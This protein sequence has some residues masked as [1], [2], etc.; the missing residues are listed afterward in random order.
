MLNQGSPGHTAGSRVGHPPELC[1]GL[2]AGA[3]DPGAHAP[4]P[5]FLPPPCQDPQPWSIRTFRKK[6]RGPRPHGGAIQLPAQLQ[7]ILGPQSTSENYHPR[8]SHKLC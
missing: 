2:P 1:R 6:S 7:W 8:N 3:A 4:S 5:S